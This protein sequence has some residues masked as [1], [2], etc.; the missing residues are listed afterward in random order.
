MALRF[1]WPEWLNH[2]EICFDFKQPANT[3]QRAKSFSKLLEIKISPHALSSSDKNS[4][5]DQFNTLNLIA[6]EQLD[7]HPNLSIESFFYKIYTEEK[8][9]YNIKELLAYI[10]RWLSITF[11]ECVV[12][13]LF[14]KILDTDDAGRPFSKDTIDNVCFIRHNGP[15]PLVAKTL[16]RSALDEYFIGLKSKQWH[17]IINTHSFFTSKSNTT[18]MKIAQDKFSLFE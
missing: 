2:S 7:L 13:A 10:L 11:N 16:V 8:L 12:E 14:S 5:K 4:L 6:E 17:F 18:E 1:E 15:H 9:Y 3:N